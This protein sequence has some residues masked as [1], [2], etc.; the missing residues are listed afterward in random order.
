MS[1]PLGLPTVD[2]VWKLALPPATQLVTGADGLRQPVQW[3]HRMSVHPP[4]L[5]AIEKSEIALLSVDALA[6][7]DERITLT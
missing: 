3:A 1:S 5:A 6:M 7:L 4:A 2:E